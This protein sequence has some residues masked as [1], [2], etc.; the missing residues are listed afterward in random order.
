MSS[1]WIVE[2]FRYQAK[3]ISKHIK[4]G[5]FRSMYFKTIFSMSEIPEEKKW[6]F[7]IGHVASKLDS[8]LFFVD[9][10]IHTWTCVIAWPCSHAEVYDFTAGIIM[11]TCMREQAREKTRVKERIETIH[12][13]LCGNVMPVK[14]PIQ[15]SRKVCRPNYLRFYCTGTAQRSLLVSKWM[16]ISVSVWL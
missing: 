8:F 13:P 5:I 11:C 16:Y 14:C 4:N 15:T 6:N 12:R 9:D 2:F 3:F 10:G 1:Q 7:R